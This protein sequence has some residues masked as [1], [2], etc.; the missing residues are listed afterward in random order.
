M[1]NIQ[2]EYCK[3][4]SSCNACLVLYHVHWWLDPV[5]HL[6]TSIPIL[7]I[8]RSNGLL[9]PYVTEFS[10]PSHCERHFTTSHSGFGLK[11]SSCGLIPSKTDQ[12]HTYTT[13]R[14]IQ[15]LAPNRI[16]SNGHFYR[17]ESVGVPKLSIRTEACFHPSPK[18]SAIQPGKHKSGGF[19]KNAPSGNN[20][21][22]TW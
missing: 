1:I 7:S 22:H 2:L 5:H 11:C 12:K 15:L 13:T 14:F 3:Q 21:T 17:R 8:F 4:K 16:K 19:Q 10:H 18:A 9:V 20:I 6:F